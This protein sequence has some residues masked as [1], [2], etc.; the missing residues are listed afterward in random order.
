MDIF[1]MKLYEFASPKKG[2]TRAEKSLS[3]DSMT[4]VAEKNECEKT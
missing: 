1:H 4:P 2:T 3:S